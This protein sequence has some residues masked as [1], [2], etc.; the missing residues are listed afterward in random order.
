MLILAAFFAVTS[1]AVTDTVMTSTSDVEFCGSC[2]TMTPLVASY[3]EDVHGGAGAE[4][5]RAKCTQCH[6]PHDNSVSYMIAKTRFGMH[7]AWAQT[8]YDLEK[9]DWEAKRSHSED[10]V[11]D[12]GCMQCHKDLERASE[13]DPKSFVAHRPYFLGTIESQC[14]TC[15]SRV[16]HKDLSAHLAA[17]RKGDKQ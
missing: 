7:D 8:F 1:W 5:V 10:Y 13:A 3:R 9:I 4:G 15:H 11:F 14:V 12:S 2:H 6:L 16:G 17:V